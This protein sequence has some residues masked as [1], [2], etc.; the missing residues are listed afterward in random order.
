MVTSTSN[1]IPNATFRYFFGNQDVYVNMN[2]PGVG[3]RY[4][5]G[6]AVSGPG[7]FTVQVHDE[8]G[9]YGDNSGDLYFVAY[10][11]D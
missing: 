3:M 6:E 8:D 7:D 2:G 11:A 5:G 10:P 1:C 9:C 4:P